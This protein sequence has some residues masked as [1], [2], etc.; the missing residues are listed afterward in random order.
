MKKR[1]PLLVMLLALPFAGFLF[2]S[3]D[4]SNVVELDFDF[5]SA[6]IIFEVAADQQTGTIE[7]VETIVPTNLDSIFEANNADISN[8]K[9]IYLKKCEFTI[10]SP[11]A[12]TFDILSDM[13]SSISAVDL[14]EVTIASGF[15]SKI[16]KSCELNLQNVN[17]AD[18]LKKPSFT[19]KAVGVT[20][21]PITEPIQMKASLKYKAKVGI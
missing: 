21:G 16:E 13:T 8:I 1:I 14:A 7:L 10:L 20:T 4:E 15:K 9:S 18:Y 3:C 19:F 12:Q 5:N 17:L 6:D 2:N 11:E